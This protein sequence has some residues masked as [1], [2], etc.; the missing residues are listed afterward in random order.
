MIASGTRAS[1]PDH[2][3]DGCFLAMIVPLCCAADGVLLALGAFAAW[4]IPW[5]GRVREAALALAGALAATVAVAATA[6]MF[7]G[8]AML[9]GACHGLFCVGLPLLAV[10]ALRVRRESRALAVALAAAFV[11]GE[12]C[13]VWARHVEPFRL[14][15]TTASVASARLASLPAPIRVAVIAD[16]QTD[17]VGAHEIAMFDRVVDARPDLVLWLGDYLQ[18]ADGETF[19]REL[20]VLQQQVRRLQPRLGSY[21]V[22]GDVDGWGLAR[23]FEG[24]GVRVVDDDRVELPGVPIDVI[25]LSRTMSRAP[26]VAGDTVRS[27]RGE[28][29]PIVIGHAPDF[30]QSVLRGGLA[31][32]ALMCA[33]HTHGGQVQLP[34]VGP[35][36]TLS[37]V[38]RWLAGGGVFR[39][40]DAWL[41]CSRGIGMERGDAPR[42]R[43]LC[44]PQLILLEL[45]GR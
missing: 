17:H 7:G 5:Q 45:A 9:R 13:Y 2:P 34:F 40:G 10:R 12:A 42:I 11:A 20:A 41:V 23:I 6:R 37:S 3:R 27:L 8:F 31:A 24:T 19:R 39:R 43:F 21:A 29:F 38:P 33:G 15:V 16:L 14:E 1:S 22:G 32:D 26:V 4:R 25:G 36:I 18:V 35:L 30:M 44:R 28:R